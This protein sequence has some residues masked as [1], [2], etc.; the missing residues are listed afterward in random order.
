MQLKLEHCYF[1][2]LLFLIH[3]SPPLFIRTFMDRI[4]S[5]M[6]YYLDE[7]SANLWQTF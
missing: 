1:Y 2:R 6:G 5:M 4:M 3:H 7:F